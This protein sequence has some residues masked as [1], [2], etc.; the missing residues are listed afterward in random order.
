MVLELRAESP[1]AYE[2]IFSCE[3]G[4]MQKPAS[5]LGGAVVAHSVR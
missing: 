2:E 1:K 4:I 3:G 5:H